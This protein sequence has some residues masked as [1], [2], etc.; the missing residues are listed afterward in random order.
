MPLFRIHSLSTA[1]LLAAAL[2]AGFSTAE[3]AAQ[4]QPAAP[5]LSANTADQLNNVFRPAYESHE[6]DKALAALDSILTSVD[7]DSYDAAYVHKAEATI[8]LQNKNNLLL[9]L[10]HL[11]QA[12]AID[13]RKHYYF[14]KDLQEILYM[15]S[16]ITFNEAVTTKDP[17]V[18]DANFARSVETL[19]R[20]IEHADIKSLTQDNFYYVSQVYFS[21]G[22]G[23]ETGTEQKG[24]RAMMEKALVWIDR[25]LRSVIHP[26][27][28]FYQL[29][30]AGLYQLDHFKEAAEYI[31]LQLKQKP[32]NKNYWQQLGSIYLQ[33]A[34]VSEEKK[35]TAASYS[36]NVRAILTIERAQKLGFL[37]APK[38]N[39][40]L[41]GI[42]S[43]INQYPMACELL[44]KGL[45]EDTIESTPQN[46]QILGGWYQMIHRDDRAIQTFLTTA[47]LFP[48]NAEIEYQLAQVYLGVPDEPSALIHIKACMAKGGTEKPYV[49]WLFYSFTA[50][51]LQKFDEALKAAHEAFLS[52]T[53]ANATDAIK[54]AQKMEET[55]KANIQDLENRKLQ[56]Q[57][58]H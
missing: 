38:D 21:L 37:T 12:L 8:Y 55:I 4:T 51:D 33:L 50:M 23:V 29:K 32:D 14:Q 22:Q 24:D 31:E 3:I 25:G 46:W 47:K 7:K 11:E 1:L 40:N 17:K 45:L 30:I 13:D 35:D 28:L 5:E 27:D 20:W 54:Q 15:I 41:V 44:E 56:L 10:Q 26:R 43:T 19:E 18:R 58:K 6:W 34:Q 36:Y 52:A 9:G 42:Y 16:Q 57:M 49:G 53:K 48:T 39:F 2:C